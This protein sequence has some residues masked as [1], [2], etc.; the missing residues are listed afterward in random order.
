MRSAKSAP[1][2]EPNEPRKTARQWKMPM[3]KHRRR[4]IAPLTRLRVGKR[5]ISSPQSKHLR[6]N[7]FQQGKQGSRLRLPFL[8]SGKL[9]PRH[10]S[11]KAWFTHL[12]EHF[13]H[14][15]VL[16]EQVVDFLHA[17]SRTAGNPFAAGAPDC[18]VVVALTFRPCID[19]WLDPIYLPFRHPFS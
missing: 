4:R 9:H 8:H 16:A 18:C 3:P 17:G 14:L 5:K 6:L 13:F 1:K 15:S 7:R 10:S 11:R 2:S 12:L 19:Y